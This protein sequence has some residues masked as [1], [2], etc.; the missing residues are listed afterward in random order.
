MS[1]ATGIRL[2][3]DQRPCHDGIGG[4]L[5]LAATWR[6]LEENTGRLLPSQI[7]IC[8]WFLDLL[9]LTPYTT[10]K[11]VSKKSLFGLKVITQNE[12]NKWGFTQIGQY[13]LLKQY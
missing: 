6:G 12:E 11:D 3:Y 9:K 8:P 13:Y 5:A 4:K 10:W 2:K 1:S 7:Q